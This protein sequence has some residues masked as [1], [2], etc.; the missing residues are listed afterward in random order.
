L[1]VVDTHP[2][3]SGANKVDELRI[4]LDFSKVDLDEW[5]VNCR[6]RIGIFAIKRDLALHDARMRLTDIPMSV[7]MVRISTFFAFVTETRI[8]RE[9]KLCRI[10]SS[11]HTR[12]VCLL[13]RKLR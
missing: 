5:T 6:P 11:H 9:R 7:A 3:P 10:F 13:S 4:A 8:M 2:M 1:I 12:L